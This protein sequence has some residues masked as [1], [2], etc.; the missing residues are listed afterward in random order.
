MATAAAHKV[1]GI[2]ELLEMVLY[3]LPPI[4][5]LVY[6]RVCQRWKDIITHGE[7]FQQALFFKPAT[8]GT[9]KPRKERTFRELA[10]SVEATWADASKPQRIF[11]NPM[12]AELIDAV[13]NGRDKKWTSQNASWRRMLLTRPSSDETCV[14]ATDLDLFKALINIHAVAM[15]RPVIFRTFKISRS[16]TS[17]LFS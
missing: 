15:H 10:S 13:K 5:I 9:L 8:N 17:S 7:K 4:D 14:M 11:L 16:I 12:L 3:E 2:T 6:Q 1:Q